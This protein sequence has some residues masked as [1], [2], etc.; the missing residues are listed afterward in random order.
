MVTR[1]RKSKTRISS[2][3]SS[4]QNQE[5][6]FAAPPVIQ[7]KVQRKT[8]GKLPQV[9]RGR[10][11]NPLERLRNSGALQTKL[12]RGRSN[13][14]EQQPAE[15]TT[16]D[17]VQQRSSSAPTAQQPGAIVQREIMETGNSLPMKPMEPIQQEAMEQ[18]NRLQTRPLMRKN[19]SNLNSV[20]QRTIV[21]NNGNDI[22]TA[23]HMD[24]DVEKEGDANVK[25]AAQALHD[26][27]QEIKVDSYEELVRNIN[28]GAYA[29]LLPGNNANAGNN[30][31]GLGAILKFNFAGS[32][33]REW[34]THTE[35]TESKK[36]KPNL[37][38]NPVSHTSKDGVKYKKQKQSRG[39]DKTVI[40]YA[41][42]LAS[43]GASDSGANS[44]A[45]NLADAK[46]EFNDYMAQ[47]LEQ[48]P[49]EIVQINIK[50]F[51]RGAATSSVFAAWIKTESDYK[52]NVAVNVVLIDP[53]HG[54][55]RAGVGQGLQPGRQDVTDVY[56]ADK[57]ATS[58]D[59]GL[60]TGTTLLIPITSDFGWVYGGAFTPQ[61]IVGAQRIIIA[62]GPGAKHFFGVAEQESSTL[63]YNDAKIKGTR[64]SELPHGVFIVNSE[65]MNIQ[66]VNGWND[67]DNKKSNLGVFKGVNKKESRDTIIDATVKAFFDNEEVQDL[68]DLQDLV[69]NIL[70]DDIDATNTNDENDFDIG[71]AFI[72]ELLDDMNDE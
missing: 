8:D 58:H 51:S 25:Q 35:G 20:V 13:H 1:R 27:P 46:K 67:W 40:E 42:P 45:N 16:S 19:T 21:D 18:D 11:S 29:H 52:D 14:P 28:S 38:L 24:E 15:G 6:Q 32:G 55:S 64:L 34:G 61:Q 57:D 54:T 26:L 59:N 65:N 48:R 5:P 10:H 63:K 60:K 33:E 12:E 71:D 39:R 2:H 43:S 9:K 53:V 62:Y 7:P 41:G 56:E 3:Q 66:K 17:V 44:T 50:G 31:N 37:E 47:V 69:N 30:A 49:N 70:Q 36:N 4:S 72:N 22:W 23:Q 68:Q